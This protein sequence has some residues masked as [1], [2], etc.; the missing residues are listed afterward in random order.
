M[1]FLSSASES[2]TVQWERQKVDSH[3]KDQF[4]IKN[5]HSPRKAS[6]NFNFLLSSFQ[7][8]NKVPIAWSS[9]CAFWVLLL[10]TGYKNCFKILIRIHSTQHLLVIFQPGQKPM[11]SLF[12]FSFATTL[13]T[14]VLS[15]HSRFLWFTP[16]G[17]F[18]NFFRSQGDFCLT[19]A[20]LHNF[21]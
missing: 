19:C 6:Q 15:S 11:R 3:K 17:F 5:N 16:F 10:Q 2:T 9:Q 12:H 20:K 14:W 7:S 4:W 1:E 8:L 13:R 21:P 18:E